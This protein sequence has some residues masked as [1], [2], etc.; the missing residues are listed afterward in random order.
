MQAPL[1]V[2]VANVLMAMP[3]HAEAGKIFDFNATLPIIAGQFLVLMVL[4]DKIFYTPVGQM[5]DERDEKIRSQLTDVKGNAAEIAELQAK[6]EAVIN[7]ARREAAD[8]INAAKA[9]AEAESA[10]KVS[11]AKE[12]SVGIFSGHVLHIVVGMATSEVNVMLYL[13]VC[14]PAISM[15]CWQQQNAHGS[16]LDRF[17]SQDGV[18]VM[19]LG[20]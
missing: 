19:I 9:K 17:H 10:A 8:A 5:I 1:S 7:D 13:V 18:Y 20:G 12:V 6:A 4:L 16:I 15:Q 11:A 3:A 14:G 2:A